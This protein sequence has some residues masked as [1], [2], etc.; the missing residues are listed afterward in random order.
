MSYS[1][2][3]FMNLFIIIIFSNYLN[4]LFEVYDNFSKFVKLLN[5]G[6]MIFQ[7]KK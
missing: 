5:F 4:K 3:L 2:F 7:T 1:I 6:N